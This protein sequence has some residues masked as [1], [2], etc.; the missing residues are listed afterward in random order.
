MFYNIFLAR[1]RVAVRPAATAPDNHP[2]QAS[3]GQNDGAP[4]TTETQ[5]EA[6]GHGRC[7][8]P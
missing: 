4:K 7:A 8:R 3:R 6:P 5:R 2:K 1:A